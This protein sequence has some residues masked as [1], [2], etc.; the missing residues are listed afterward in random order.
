[1]GYRRYGNI[2]R[3]APRKELDA[4]DEAEAAR[5]AAAAASEMPKPEIVTLNYASADE[6]RPKLEGMLSPKGKI[7]VDGRMN[8]LIVN[9]IAANR[10]Q[11]VALALQLDIQTPQ[12]SIEARIVEARSTFVR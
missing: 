10:Q 11:I 1:L 6:L 2:Y 12:I 7:E 8:S 4:E 3:I 9:D 5:R